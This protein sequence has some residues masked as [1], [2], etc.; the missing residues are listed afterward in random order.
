MNYLQKRLIDLTAAEFI[1]LLLE[2]LSTQKLPQKTTAAPPDVLTTREVARLTGYSEDHVRQ[3]AHKRQIPFFKGE[4]RKPLRFLR[5][6]VTEWMLG[7]KYTP[8]DD[9]AEAHVNGNPIRSNLKPKS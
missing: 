1:S 7:R 4:G 8:L 9:L 3:L 6:E 5:T 2:G